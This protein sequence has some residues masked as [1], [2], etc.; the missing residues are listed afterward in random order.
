[1]SDHNDE[2]EEYSDDAQQEYE[3]TIRSWG[4][5]HEPGEADYHDIL[6]EAADKD[7]AEQLAWDEIDLDYQETG[8]T[9]QVEP[10]PDLV[11]DGGTQQTG[12]QRVY[13]ARMPG[14][15]YVTRVCTLVLAPLGTAVWAFM[16]LPGTTN[17]IVGGVLLAFVV[18][19]AFLAFNQAIALT[20]EELNQESIRRLN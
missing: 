18:A 5:S 7:E 15:N 19:G 13:S 3:V 17:N 2:T 8:E 9:V 14:H 11:T 6:V 12:D 4:P 1:M 20:H 16:E 10:L